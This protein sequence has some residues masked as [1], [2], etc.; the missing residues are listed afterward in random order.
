MKTIS[1]RR[2]VSA[3]PLLGVGLSASARAQHARDPATLFEN[4]RIVDGKSGALTDRSDLVVRGNI[5]ERIETAPIAAE[6]GVGVIDGGGRTLMPGLTDMHWHM[7]LVRPTPAAL[8][9]GD[10]GH[11]NLQAGAEATATLLRGFTTVRDMG[12]PVFG[13]KR[14]IDE[15]VLPGP[16][17][18]P[19]GAII[20][21]TSGHGD[22]RPLFE[23]PRSWDPAIARRA[24]RC[25]HDRR[26]PRRGP[27][28]RSR[29][30]LAG[31]L[32]INLTAGGG[33]ASAHARSMR[34]PSPNLSCAP[35]LK[36]PKTGGHTSPSTL[37]RR[38]RS[39]G[40][41]LQA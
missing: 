32:P 31:R 36:R 33:V 40:R 16:R 34:P 26:F 4:V 3:L 23:L 19:S 18:Y 30:A 1:H 15:G 13:L 20:T 5:I 12:G 6:L 11:L 28:A 22:F 8:L 29:A 27:C 17:I 9:T 21:I 39:S 7:M 37:I 14:A 35:P 38:F 2:F 10:V 24:D 41:L 25:G